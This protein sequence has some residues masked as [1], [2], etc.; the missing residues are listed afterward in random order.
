MP[1]FDT[2]WIGLNWFEL[3]WFDVTWFP[4]LHSWEMC[5]LAVSKSLQLQVTLLHQFSS[6]IISF[7]AFHQKSHWR[8]TT[9][10]EFRFYFLMLCFDVLLPAFYNNFSW[11][12][13]LFGFEKIIEVPALSCPWKR[14]VPLPQTGVLFPCP[15]STY[16]EFCSLLPH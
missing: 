9:V 15:P 6:K 2:V 11:L 12:I 1:W 10:L 14:R 3:I 7:I 5:E 8:T 4:L 16:A 13:L